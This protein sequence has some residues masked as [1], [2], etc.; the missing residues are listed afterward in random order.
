MDKAHETAMINSLKITLDKLS[1]EGK[2]EI[3]NYITVKLS[4]TGTISME[5]VESGIVKL[6]KK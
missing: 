5:T 3:L 6:V 4:D 2:I 1:D